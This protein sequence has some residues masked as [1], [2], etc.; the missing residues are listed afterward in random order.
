MDVEFYD[1]NDV[2]YDMLIMC[3]CCQQAAGIEEAGIDLMVKVG[4]AEP[5]PG[6]LVAL[7]LC[8]GTDLW[9]IPPTYP[10][11]SRCLCTKVQNMNWI[12]SRND[13]LPCTALWC[14]RSI[15]RLKDIIFALLPDVERLMKCD[16]DISF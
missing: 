14:K 12:S 13:I 10:C 16:R 1:A 9:K 3:M 8:T 6:W 4:M 7:S 11:Y 5:R 15:N 2:S